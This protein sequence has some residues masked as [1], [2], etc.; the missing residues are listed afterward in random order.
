MIFE[1]NGLICCTI[2]IDLEEL[3]LIKSNL[4]ESAGILSGMD[5]NASLGGIIDVLK[6]LEFTDDQYSDIQRA[7]KASKCDLLFEPE[8]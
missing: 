2:A 1:H 8:T 5:E 6:A 4:L 3:S 7:L